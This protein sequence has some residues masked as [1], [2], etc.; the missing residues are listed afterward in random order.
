MVGNRFAVST[1]LAFATVS[2]AGAN[3]QTPVIPY[4]HLPPG[5]FTF[6]SLDL[7]TAS[8]SDLAALPGIGEAGAKRII[9]G[10]PYRVPHE[11]LDRKIVPAATYM[12]I[13]E[14]L[15]VGAPSR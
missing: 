6:R 13:K 8:R 11:L 12:K 14:R 5:N 10:R 7:N 9:K 15:I 2:G 4:N 3:A 1:I